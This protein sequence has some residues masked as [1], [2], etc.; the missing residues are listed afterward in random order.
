MGDIGDTGNKRIT[1]KKIIDPEVD[2]ERHLKRLQKVFGVSG[3]IQNLAIRRHKSPTQITKEV[4]EKAILAKSKGLRKDRLREI[5]QIHR[6]ILEVIANAFQIDTDK[7]IDGIIDSDWYIE[8]LRS[9]V[10]KNG[11]SVIVFFYDWFP[12]PAIG[13]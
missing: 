7:A 12:Y 8:L 1:V 6:Y 9:F 3:H 4:E 2:P 13:I 10:N 5:G 11:R